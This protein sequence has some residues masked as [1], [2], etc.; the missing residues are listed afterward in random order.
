M[1]IN[2]FDLEILVELVKKGYVQ[3][4]FS[5]I[6][7]G[8]QQ[9]ASCFLRSD[10]KIRELSELLG[11]PYPPPL[12]LDHKVSTEINQN[13]GTLPL[14]QGAPPSRIFWKWMGL[15]YK[16]VDLDESHDS[17]FI[18]LNYDEVEHKELG[19]YQIVTNY[20]TTEHLANQLNAF[21]IIHD[22]TSVG[23]IMIHHIPT[24]GMQNHGLVNY[25][26]KFFWMLARSNLYE[27]VH[28]DYFSSIPEKL[29]PDILQECSKFS[30]LLKVRQEDYRFADSSI[31]MIMKK[32]SDIPFIAPLDVATGTKTSNQ[33]LKDRY[34]TVFC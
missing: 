34:P 22:L 25:N 1:A 3:K 13:V 31:M 10:H 21:K 33:T 4:G 26:P 32:T 20:G 8:A 16:S 30:S 2:Q 11:L 27:W 6:E 12:P 28:M 17:L 5:I 24:Q 7:I 15:N 19:K 9:I 29:H 18:D 14:H 23:G